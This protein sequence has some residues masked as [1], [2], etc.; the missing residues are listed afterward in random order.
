MS[1]KR[2]IADIPKVNLADGMA[3][4]KLSTI[5]QTCY[6]GYTD[7]LGDDKRQKWAEK[8]EG[9]IELAM[10]AEEE[11]S[12]PWEGCANIKIPLLTEAA[13]KFN[14]RA[15]PTLIPPTNIVKTTKTGADPNGEKAKRGERIGKHMSYQ[16][17]EEMTE[18]EAD[19]DKGLL[20]LPIVGC[21]FKKTFYNTDLG[22]NESKLVMPQNL[23]M[24]Y[25]SPSIDRAPRLS[26]EISFYPREVKEK[27][28]TKT[29]LDT[30]LV[31]QDEEKELLEVFICQ[32]TCLDI[33]DTGYKIPYIVTLHKETQKVMRIVANYTKSDIYYNDGTEIVSVQDV[34]IKINMQNQKIE[35]N[36]IEALAIAQ[37]A[38][39]DL[40]QVAQVPEVPQQDYSKYKVTR[41]DPTQYYTKYGFLPSP[42]GGIYDIGLG[43]LMG[44]L[45]DA[46]D[47]LI[48]QSLDAGSLANNQG[49]FRAKGVKSPS[50]TGRVNV[51]EWTEI[52]TGSMSLKDA[53]VPFN[54]KGPSPVALAL[55]EFL[56]GFAKE[57]SNLKDILSGDAP[58]GETATTSMIKREEGMR[59]Y[60]AIYKRVYR[61]F[62]AELAKLY[63][64]NAEYLPQ[65]VYFTVLD[66]ET[67]IKQTDYSH[68]KTDVR[69]TADP[70]ESTQAQKMMKVEA[71]LQF[72]GDPDF[73]GYTLKKNYME[74]IDYPNIDEALPPQ[75]PLEER[76]K[77]PP[78][79]NI[80]KITAE[81]ENLEAKT[82]KTYLETAE[83]ISKVIL[84][85]ATA[86]SKE[87]GDQIGILKAH[88]D[89]LIKKGVANGEGR[90][91]GVEP[92][93]ND[94]SAQVLS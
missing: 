26:E 87:A 9:Y 8:N 1:I 67:A 71:G 43:Q 14:A 35:G 82:K 38:G 69:P 27:Q 65:E 78:D 55:I 17:Q 28:N 62:K 25:D 34:E 86:E 11:K 41:V 51:N 75:P 42:D 81:V 58:A 68:D 18:W 61:A 54:F 32:H 50:G 29:W 85:L 7:D 83:V 57:V 37:Q 12:D 30:E 94:G 52:E 39:Q 21:F 74:A 93:P 36:N 22:R 89:L 63:D 64:L 72:V 44:P 10:Q 59:I 77:P 56:I 91:G 3:E 66:E 76:P 79:P 84:N 33:H 6:Q 90:N 88:A 48:N 46:A 60:N 23:V 19:M 5:G 40:K 15:Y 70:T 16:L 45:T 73:D 24:K 53:I 92:T 2:L 49:G 47:T 13:I 80:V 31:F 4:D 20:I